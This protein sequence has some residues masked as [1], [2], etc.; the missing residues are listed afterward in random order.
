[1]YKPWRNHGAFASLQHRCCRVMAEV[2]GEGQWCGVL[3]PS[4][5]KITTLLFTSSCLFSLEGA[6]FSCPVF[7]RNKHT[8]FLFGIERRGRKE[9]M[10]EET[11]EG[12]I[13]TT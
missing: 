9:S 11:K 12:R 13:S 6:I 5:K 1:M 10:Q 2:P 3:L 4:A 7:L 8:F